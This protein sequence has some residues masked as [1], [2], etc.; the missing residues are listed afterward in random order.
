MPGCWSVPLVALKITNVGRSYGMS[1]F[2]N[3]SKSSYGAAS[4]ECIPFEVRTEAF[5]LCYSTVIALYKSG[6]SLLNF[7]EDVYAYLLVGIPNSIPVLAEE[8][9]Y[10]LYL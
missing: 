5:Q 2:V 8:E 10:K 3:C 6:C 1:F 4:L 7:F 9:F